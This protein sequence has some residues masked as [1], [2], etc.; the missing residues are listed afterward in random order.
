MSDKQSRSS[1]LK[2]G[3]S[4]SESRPIDRTPAMNLYFRLLWIALSSLW[5]GRIHLLDESSISRR[6]RP[7]DIDLN[8]HVNNGRY[9]TLADLGRMDFFLRCGLMGLMFKHKWK[10]I[11]AGVMSRYHR[12]LV[13][14]QPYI[15]TTQI[16]GWDDKWAYLEHRF[17]RVNK[18]VATIVV[19]G[20]FVGPR[21]RVSMQEVVE[22]LGFVGGSPEIPAAIRSWEEAQT[23][24]A[25]ARDLC[26]LAEMK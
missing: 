1:S 11:I 22:A 8:L 16:L 19:K 5:R 9:L 3:V 13:L 17:E 26:P 23:A 12:G 25:E 21:G 2:A 18:V 4:T 14:F 20:L 6:V 7:G 10:P 15:I 24:Q